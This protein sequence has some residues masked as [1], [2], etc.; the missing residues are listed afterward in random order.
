MESLQID[1]G[2]I[3][4]YMGQAGHE[5]EAELDGEI[6]RSIASIRSLAVP[7][8]AVRVFP[9]Y[10]GEHLQAGHTTLQLAG[11]DIERHLLD[12][13]R[14][15]VLAVTLGHE[16]DRKIRSSE[17]A[18]MFRA[19]VLDA[20]ASVAVESLAERTEQC[21]AAQYQADGIFHTGRYSPGYGDFPLQTQSAILDVLDA[22]RAI[23]LTATAYHIL[24]PRKS[25]TAVIGLSSECDVSKS[26]SCE[27]CKLHRSC[28]FRVERKNR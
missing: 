1:K 24:L 8:V 23:G 2:D 10:R 18:S 12:C 4:R 7:R 25:I 3:L 9:L 20:C 6:E 26:R 28:A 27:A 21:I 22:E 14:V 19:L 16:V 13:D 15:A 11:S 17:P 5:P